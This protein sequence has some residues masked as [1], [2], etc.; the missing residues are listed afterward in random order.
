MSEEK[1]LIEQFAEEH[2][3]MDDPRA[4]SMSA[5]NRA[6]EDWKNNQRDQDED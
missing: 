4:T 6:F 5:F 1:T 3:A 2:P